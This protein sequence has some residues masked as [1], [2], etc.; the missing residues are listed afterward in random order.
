M[1]NTQHEYWRNPN[2]QLLLNVTQLEQFSLLPD[3]LMMGFEVK[4]SPQVNR[5]SPYLAGA[6]IVVFIAA[7]SALIVRFFLKE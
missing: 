7:S 1:I 4:K 5:S 2:S 3:N 6:F